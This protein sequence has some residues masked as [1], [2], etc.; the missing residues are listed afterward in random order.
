[1]VNSANTS[2]PE[3]SYCN[4]S[5]FP[6]PF[7]MS[8]EFENIE[9]SIPMSDY[10]L[11]IFHNTP[12]TYPTNTDI[13]CS[14]TITASL[15]PSSR[16]WVGVY[17]VGWRSARE[18]T[19]FD[20]SKIPEGYQKGQ[21]IDVSITFSGEY[22]ELFFCFLSLLLKNSNLILTYCLLNLAVIKLLT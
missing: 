10:A 11:V 19:S 3:A 1:M 12:E 20:W 8:G 2:T 15:E 13:E 22:G 9:L 17:K 14:Y 7:R 18:Y 16:D 4:I 6:P 5:F 21:K